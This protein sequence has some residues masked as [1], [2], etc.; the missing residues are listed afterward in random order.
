MSKTHTIRK[1]LNLPLIGAPV[2]QVEEVAFSSSFALSP[3]EFTGLSPKLAV[4][5]GDAILAGQCLFHDK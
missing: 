1:G 5:E 4:K 2:A 3:D